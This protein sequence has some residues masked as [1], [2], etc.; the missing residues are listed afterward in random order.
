A[1]DPERALGGWIDDREGR[2]GEVP[3]ISALEGIDGDTL[4]V[5]AQVQLA[6]ADRRGSL[7]E[8]LPGDCSLPR[9]GAGR[10]VEG[11]DDAGRG[12]GDGEAPADRLR[13]R[14]GEELLERGGEV[15]GERLGARRVGL[16]Q[17]A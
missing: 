2:V 1:R 7:Q 3:E 16:P 11:E 15:V 8:E 5:E 13:Q 17:A 10:R 6:P 14:T 4:I 12:C 9:E